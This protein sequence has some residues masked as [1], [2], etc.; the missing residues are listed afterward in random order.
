[1]DQDIIYSLDFDEI[2][3]TLN[4]ILILHGDKVYIG[5]LHLLANP[6]YDF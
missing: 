4:C 3:Q 5:I 6:L 1:M 2:P